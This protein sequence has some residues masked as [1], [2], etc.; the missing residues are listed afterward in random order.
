VEGLTLETTRLADVFSD[1]K[2]IQEHMAVAVIVVNT[3]QRSG[4]LHINAE[5]LP[6]FPREGGTGRLTGLE[7]AA[8]KLPK[9]ALVNA[10][11]SASHQNTPSGV[12]QGA[13]GNV[14]AALAG[15]VLVVR[16]GTRR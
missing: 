1:Q 14:D 2:H 10:L 5:L 9:A 13:G 15:G 3:N 16:S 12:L 8:G 4:R 6:Q 11:R 7:L